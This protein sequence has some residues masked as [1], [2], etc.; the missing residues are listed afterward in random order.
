ME[1][2][3]ILLVDDHEVIRQ[4]LQ[5]LLGTQRGWEV[6][7]EAVDGREAVEK[8]VQLKPDIVILDISMPGI[9]GL[10]ATPLILAAAPRSDILIFTVHDSEL[11][12]QTALQAGA[13]AFVR[14]SDAARDLVA[15][16]KALSQHSTFFPSRV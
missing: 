8:A 11:M 10:E 5:A 4:G 14:K 12:E 13:R 7:G 16:V 6:V 2:L 1:N 15:A 3:R 9:N